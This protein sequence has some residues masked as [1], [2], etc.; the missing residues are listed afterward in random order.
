M[1]FVETES[2]GRIILQDR[3]GNIHL[4]QDGEDITWTN[5]ATN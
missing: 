4:V 1:T 2:K 3:M 5:Y